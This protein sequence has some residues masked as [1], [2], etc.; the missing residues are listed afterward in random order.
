MSQRQQLERILLIDRHIRDGRFPN[1]DSLA[2]ELEVSRRVIYVDRQFMLERL[3]APIANDRKR[4][5]WYYSNTTWML[6]STMISEGELLAFVLGA[7]AA[8]RS[9][10]TALEGPLQAAIAKIAQNLHGPVQVD[11]QALQQHC[12]FASSSAV[13][14]NE[15][16]LLGLHAAI[17]EC[18]SVRIEY[19]TAER[20]THTERVIDPYH[21]HHAQGNWYV[22]GFDHYRNAIRNFHVGRIVS[23]QRLSQ[24]F[25]RNPDFDAGQWLSEMFQVSRGETM[26]EVV[27]RF[28]A[29][30]ATYIRER[31][32]H[33]TQT[34]EEL[35]PEEGL[36]L[37]FQTSSWGEVLRF[38]M[39]YGAHAEVLSPPELREEIAEHLWLLNDLYSM[40]LPCTDNEDDD[41]I[42]D[43]DVTAE[44]VKGEEVTELNVARECLQAITSIE[45]LRALSRRLQAN[46]P[47]SDPRRNAL[48]MEIGVRMLNLG[49]DPWNP[50]T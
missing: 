13:P 17:Q 27:I 31:Q 4:G 46:L 37:R 5:G 9:V 35:G 50:Q 44:K 8:R 6:P 22:I 15:Q 32:W 24:C 12:S 7:E 1:A 36:I 18:R 47:I 43:E 28:N 3:G 21:L 38:V 11:L 19:Y 14:T 10:G 34:I 49:F 16:T 20:N 40:E 29:Y 30:Q 39:Q 23:L 41:E 2:A 42:T 45:E 33:P 26:R 25:Q 48:I